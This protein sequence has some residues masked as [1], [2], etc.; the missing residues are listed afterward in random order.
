MGEQA[1]V[2]PEQWVERHGDAMFRYALLQMGDRE[3]AEERV[4][5][6]FVAALEARHSFAGASSERTWLISILRHKICDYFRRRGREQPMADP[7]EAVEAVAGMFNKHGKWRDAP[8]RWAGNPHE[9][10]QRGEFWQAL[11]QCL[12]RLPA[13]LGDAFQLREIQGLT[14]EKVCALLGLSTTNLSTRL[15][16]ARALLRRCLELAWFG[17]RPSRKKDR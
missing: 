12:T 1:T 13:P 14:G 11:R 4:Q 15:S 2:N 16:R 10:L 6:A 8:V 3:A 5:E 17:K 7:H 9:L